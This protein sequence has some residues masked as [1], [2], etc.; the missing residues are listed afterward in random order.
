MNKFTLSFFGLARYLPDISISA[1][2]STI[3]CSSYKTIN[4][5]NIDVFA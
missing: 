2:L 1:A 4:I 5:M 3:L